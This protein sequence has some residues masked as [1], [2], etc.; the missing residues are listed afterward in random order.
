MKCHGSMR[1]PKNT[2]LARKIAE[3]LEHFG[4][5]IPGG[6]DNACIDRS[7]VPYHL[8]AQGWGAWSWQ[9]A[10]VDG[11]H[12]IPSIGSIYSATEIAETF[13]RDPEFAEEMIDV[14]W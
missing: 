14:G 6:V 12:V 8:R 9:I 5:E 13:K 3:I 10:C 4:Y 2:R 1:Q 11:R 7:Y